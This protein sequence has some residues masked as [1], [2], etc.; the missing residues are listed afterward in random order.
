MRLAT[1]T[2][3]LLVLSL[4]TIASPALAEEKFT[5][6]QAKGLTLRA[7]DLIQAKGLEGARAILHEEGEFRHGELYVNV[8]DMAGIWL[9]YPPMPSGEGRSVLQVKD[10]NGKFIV[11]E[12]IKTANEQGEGW[13]EYRWINPETKVIGPKVSYVKRV[14]GT[15]MIVYV[16]IYK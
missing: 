13:I 3:C 16:G 10:T 12:V 5:P 14:P 1:L 4:A 6:E 11:Q 15:D 2:V 8:I 7:A 9:V